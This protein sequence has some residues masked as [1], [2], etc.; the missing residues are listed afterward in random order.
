MW[1]VAGS[2]LPLLPGEALTLTLHDAYYR[3][4]LSRLPAMTAAG[5]WLYAQ[6]DSADAETDYGAVLE[7][8]EVAGD[9]YNNVA[10]P[11]VAPAAFLLESP[12][13]G[14]GSSGTLPRC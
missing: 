11:V 7:T 12:R 2:A 14:S 4:A 9:R 5:T 13:I 8:H 1:G 6:V 10:G 3:P